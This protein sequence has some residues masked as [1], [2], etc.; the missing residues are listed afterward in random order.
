M[1]VKG[2]ILLRPIENK[3]I[4]RLNE[5]KNDEE[6]YK[7][8][9]GGFLP[10][11]INQQEKWMESLIDT[12]GQ[13]KRFIICDQNKNSIGM[14]GLYNINWIHRVAEVGIFIGDKNSQGKGYAKEAYISIEGFARNY[15]NLRKIKLNVVLSNE[16]ATKLW[17]SVNFIEVGRLKDERFIDG[18][19]MDLLIME[20]FIVHS[21]LN[22]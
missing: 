10:T 22:N 15:L 4:V 12:T 17:E 8:L 13:N 14:V 2:R 19:Y 1:I 7:Y 5:W 9:G 6:T 3:D 20:K 21:E 11:S 18:K 16:K